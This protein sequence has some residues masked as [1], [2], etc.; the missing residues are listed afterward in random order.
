[1]AD[2]RGS[3]TTDAPAHGAAPAAASAYQG[4]GA[5]APRIVRAT[6]LTGVHIL[7][8]DNLFMLSDAYGD[9]HIDGRGLG[10]YARDTRVLSVYE[11][12][13]NGMRPVVLRAGPAVSY[14]GTIQLTNPDQFDDEADRV[15][16]AAMILSRHSL[17]IVRER[18][19]GSGF[20]ERITVQNYT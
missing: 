10:L 15:D 7:K 1:M 17:G 2:A 3:A 19:I 9:I 5:P 13:L 18:V 16:P 11:L 14:R 20:G 6:D 4:L 12:R 8:H